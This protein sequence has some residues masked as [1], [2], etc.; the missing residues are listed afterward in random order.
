[1]GKTGDVFISN[2][3]RIRAKS[4]LTQNELAEKAGLSSGI[5]GLIE[6]GQRNPTLTTIEQIANALSI[7]AYYLF[8]DPTGDMPGTDLNRRDGFKVELYALLDAYWGESS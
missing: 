2:L 1:M 8:Y 7:P 6:T 5:I 4:G 3:K